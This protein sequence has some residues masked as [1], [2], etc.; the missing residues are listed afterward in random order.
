MTGPPRE[1]EE[2]EE[3]EKAGDF[4]AQVERNKWH[5]GGEDL[6]KVQGPGPDPGPD[7]TLDRTGPRTR[8][9]T[10]LEYSFTTFHSDSPK[11]KD[12]LGNQ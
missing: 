6:S 7:R 1:E 8:D 9:R 4:S 5:V 12:P 10:T 2:S 3:E 11:K